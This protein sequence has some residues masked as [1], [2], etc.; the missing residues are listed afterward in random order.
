MGN[1]IEAGSVHREGMI[2]LIEVCLCELQIEMPRAGM[3]ETMCSDS[4][5]PACLAPFAHMRR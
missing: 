3:C 1:E 5:P 4:N 2:E